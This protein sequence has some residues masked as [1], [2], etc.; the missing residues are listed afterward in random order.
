VRALSTVCRSACAFAI[1]AGALVASV[2]CG[3]AQPQQIP[4]SPPCAIPAGTQT[5]LIYPAP[6]SWGAGPSLP[7]VYLASTT[8]LP[9][10]YSV[11]IVSSPQPASYTAYY[12]D[13]QTVKATPVPPTIYGTLAGYTPPPATFS[14][15]QESSG[16]GTTWTVGATLSVYLADNYATSASSPQCIPLFIGSFV[17]GPSPT[18]TPAHT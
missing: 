13:L 17:V 14:S 7:A 12:S 15:I 10:N 2:S 9:N 8:A 11:D 18:P 1:A 6:N 16:P 5:A 3:P 4:I